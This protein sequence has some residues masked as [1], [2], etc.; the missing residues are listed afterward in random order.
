MGTKVVDFIKAI[1]M[2]SFLA[3]CMMAAVHAASVS[4]GE[5]NQP[6]FPYVSITLMFPVLG[7]TLLPVIISTHRQEAK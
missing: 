6:V 2:A 5:A 4:A 7:I 1:Y 3:T